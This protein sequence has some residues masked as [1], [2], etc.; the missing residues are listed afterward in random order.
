MAMIREIRCRRGGTVRIYD[1]CILPKAQ[2][3]ELL[4]RFWREADACYRQ[5]QERR[6]RGEQVRPDYAGDWPGTERQ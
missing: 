4:K 5:Y 3:G 6:A 1:D 2:Q